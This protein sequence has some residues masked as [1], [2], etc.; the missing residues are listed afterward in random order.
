MAMSGDESDDGEEE[1]FEEIT[2]DG[3][4]EMCV[5]GCISGMWWRVWSSLARN[6]AGRTH[7]SIKASARVCTLLTMLWM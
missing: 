4:E 3:E 6:H 5:H 2:A 1:E 7:G